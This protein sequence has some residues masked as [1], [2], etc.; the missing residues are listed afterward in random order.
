MLNEGIAPKTS[1]NRRVGPHRRMAVI[2]GD[3]DTF[4]EIA[5]RIRER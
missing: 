5:H 2:R 4:R 3:L 1:L